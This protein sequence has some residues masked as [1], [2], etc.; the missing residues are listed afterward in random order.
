MYL[1]GLRG[2]I[3]TTHVNLIDTHLMQAERYLSELV[4]MPMSLHSVEVVNRLAAA[5]KLPSGFMRAFISHCISSCD[6]AEVTF[7]TIQL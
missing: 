5:A 2:T 1:R 6:L 4:S 7:H 3:Y